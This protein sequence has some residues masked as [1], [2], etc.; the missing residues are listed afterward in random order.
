MSGCVE[1]VARVEVVGAPGLGR[2]AW[3]LREIDPPAP[4][5][6]AEAGGRGGRGGGRGG[7]GGGGDPVPYGRY[8]AQLVRIANGAET[9]LGAAQVFQVKPLPQ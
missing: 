3:N 7:R 2:A 4:G 5:D 1:R 6:A 9:P 8:T